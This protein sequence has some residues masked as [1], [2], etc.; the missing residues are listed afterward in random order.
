MMWAQCTL[1]LNFQD[2]FPASPPAGAKPRPHLSPFLLTI[3][4][5]RPASQP[6]HAMMQKPRL[7]G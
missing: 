3:T 4:T 6:Q 7:A 1:L 5:D 2:V